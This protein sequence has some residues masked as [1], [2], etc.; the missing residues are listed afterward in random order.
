MGPWSGL[1]W[2][3]DN[4]W[5]DD[6]RLMTD[7]RIDTEIFESN[8]L[9]KN[10]EA[11]DA[12]GNDAIQMSISFGAVWSTLN[13][14]FEAIGKWAFGLSFMEMQA[15][16]EGGDGQ[17]YIDQLYHQ[18]NVHALPAYSAWWEAVAYGTEPITTLDDFRNI[19]AFRSGPGLQLEV[20]QRAGV[21][22]VFLSGA[23][24][25]SALER[26]VVEATKFGAPSETWGMKFHEI[27]P[28]ITWRAWFIPGGGTLNY[29]WNLD[30][31]NALSDKDKTILTAATKTRRM[32]SLQ[33]LAVEGEYWKN[34]LDYGCQMHVL[35]DPS[36]CE[37]YQIF[38][39]VEAEKFDQSP[40]LKEIVT[41]QREFTKYLKEY[42]SYA[43][44]P[45]LECFKS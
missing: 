6:V 39:E 5:A 29:E 13:P 23:E 44:L 12:V 1:I 2:E 27:A 16:F 3:L 36:L 40:L 14:A 4:K 9:M 25:Y 19:K 11:L 18:Y 32:G 7:G 8:A 41:N 30:R 21:N 31:W 35:D 34:Y 24:T 10:T 20:L 17:Q 38:R 37:L 26:G 15:W 28:N 42:V 22:A 43:Q 33:T 45:A